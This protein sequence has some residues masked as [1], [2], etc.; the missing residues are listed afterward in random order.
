[1][2][3]RG[4]PSQAWASQFPDDYVPALLELILN[5][6][7]TFSVPNDLHENPITRHFCA[8][9]QNNKNRDKHFFRIEWESTDLDEDGN[10]LGRIDLKFIGFGSCDEK[11]YFSVE[12][13]RLRVTFPGGTFASLARQ[14][15][16]EGMIRYFNG[17]YVSG[18][19]KGGMLGYVMDGDT[20]TAI[21]D[22]KKAVEA[23]RS[24]LQMDLAATLEASGIV[25]KKMVKQTR[26]STRDSSS[27]LIHHIFL[28]VT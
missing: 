20:K 11:V 25:N 7:G 1:M 23:R 3:T 18:L 28:P 24:I 26:H 6:W 5:S 12:C 27:F 16:E 2:S 9:L 15:V 4:V 14:Y 8:H 10:E 17:Q 22:V 19:N 21:T 13:K